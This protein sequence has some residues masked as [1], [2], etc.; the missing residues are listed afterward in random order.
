MNIGLH[1]NHHLNIIE[2]PDATAAQI[3]FF[4]ERLKSQLLPF[5][6]SKNQ[7]LKTLKPA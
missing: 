4:I 7:G 6:L 1:F 2:G 5:Q 3:G